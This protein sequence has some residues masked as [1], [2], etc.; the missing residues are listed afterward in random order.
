VPA[1]KARPAAALEARDRS[2]TDQSSAEKISAEATP[3]IL[4]TQALAVYD[5]QVCIGHLLKRR[6]QGFEAYDINTKSIGIFT[7]V[8]A[9]ADA[10]AK[11]AGGTS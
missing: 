5:G 1:P 6:R 2:G 9:A 11:A 3:D 8:K 4:A 10:V 7:D